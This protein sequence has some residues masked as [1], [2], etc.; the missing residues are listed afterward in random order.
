MILT[1]LVMF[2]FFGG[3]SDAGGGAGTPSGGNILVMWRR[4]QRRGH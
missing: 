4:T 1:H 2:R 3:A